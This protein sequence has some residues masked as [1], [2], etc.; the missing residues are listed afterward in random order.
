MK[1]FLCEWAPKV[2]AVSDQLTET[3][4]AIREKDR[5]CNKAFLEFHAVI[6]RIYPSLDLLDCVHMI[7]EAIIIGPIRRILFDPSANKLDAHPQLY[8]QKIVATLKPYKVEHITDDLS[9][10]YEFIQKKSSQIDRQ[11]LIHELYE[12]FFSVALPKR[13]ARHKKAFGL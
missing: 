6:K 13:V 11:E 12:N 8:E 1:D 10:L 5:D 3:I 4:D 9:P 7:S 2:S